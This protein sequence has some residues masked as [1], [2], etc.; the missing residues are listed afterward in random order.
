M[1]SPKQ[2]CPE[3]KRLWAVLAA[4]V[5]TALGTLLVVNLAADRKKLERRI[6]SSYGVDH[7]QFLRTMGSLLGP[8]LLE[9]NRVVGLSNGDEIFPAMLAAIRS[10]QRTITFET[11]IYWSGR[12][13]ADFADALSERARAG[14]KV[15]LI[16]DWVGAGKIDEEQLQRMAEAGVEIQKYHPPRWYTL[17]RLNNRTHRRILVA[18]GRVGFTGGV[19]IGD[20]WLG[21]AQDPDHWRDAHF[22]LE[23]PAVAQM[24][25]AFAENWLETTGVLLH[26]EDYFPSLAA[27]GGS[28]AQLFKSSAA[29]GSEN[30]QLMYLLSIASARRSVRIAASY[31]V[32]DDLSVRTLVEARERGVSVV[33]L[34]PG[35]LI[36]VPLTRKASRA[37][38]GD[39]LRAGVE[40]HEYQ[41]TMY[42][43]KVMIVDELWVSVGST[44]FDDRSFR[45]NDEVNLDVYDRDFAL[46]Q[47]RIFEEDLLHG[48]KI[49]LAD[50]EGRPWNEK[51]TE[52]AAALFRSQL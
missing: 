18:D 31:F 29:D 49:R 11:Y 44:N 19:G 7:P 23:G 16:L 43:C 9:G 6:S 48:R 50:W 32:P 26:G 21:H 51:L 37:R 5:V 12:V 13:G 15:H 27:Q 41:P 42:H 45:L 25:S 36:D 33:I 14:V 10:A 20:E 52:H 17:S 8:P 1:P 22:Q 2:R 35:P 39:L 28:L 46:E 38:W 4:V 24:Q 40:I 47:V 3:R 30:I 34:V